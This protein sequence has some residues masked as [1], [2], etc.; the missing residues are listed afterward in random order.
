MKNHPWRQGMIEGVAVRPLQ[1]YHDDRGWLAEI[2]REDELP[3][4]LRPAM[5]YISL[6]R[7]GVARGPH[8]HRDQTD[9]FCFP[10]PGRFLVWLWDSRPDSATSGTRQVVEAG[11]GQPALIIIPPGVVHA[12]RNVSTEEGLVFNCPNALYRGRGKRETVDE[13]RHEDDPDTPFRLE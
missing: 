5:A 10:G 1:A 8:E 2:Y 11:A 3:P 12:Y 13:I 6:T 7:P 9:L 4:A